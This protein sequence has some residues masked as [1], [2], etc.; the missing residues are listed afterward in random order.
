[1]AGRGWTRLLTAG[2]NLSVKV[3]LGTHLHARFAALHQIFAQAL[4]TTEAIGC[5]VTVA[6]LIQ[7]P[8]SLQEVTTLAMKSNFANS[9]SILKRFWRLEE[10]IS[11]ENYRYR[12]SIN[13]A[14]SISRRRQKAES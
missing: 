9:R 7:C 13:G 10:K 14:R 1:M 8:A 11:F 3:I 2:A 5:T 6:S 4:A 12:Y